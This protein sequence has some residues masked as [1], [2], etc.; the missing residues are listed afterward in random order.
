MREKLNKKA[1]NWETHR[2]EI[3]CTSSKN[4]EKRV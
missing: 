3:T 1:L 2:K 4:C